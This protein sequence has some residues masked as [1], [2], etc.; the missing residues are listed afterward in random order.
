MLRS[1]EPESTSA[2]VP[3]D[4]V[5]SHLIAQHQHQ[6]YLSSV[7]ARR[8]DHRLSNTVGWLH[9]RYSYPASTARDGSKCK[10]V[11]RGVYKPHFSSFLLL[12]HHRLCFSVIVKSSSR[13]IHPRDHL[14]KG[15]LTQDRYSI[16]SMAPTMQD[17]FC[18]RV[19]SCNQGISAKYTHEP[20]F[21]S[22]DHLPSS[23]TMKVDG[24]W[25]RSE[26]IRS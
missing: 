17:T 16:A 11:K 13:N 19:L 2:L 4:F 14:V 1:P 9:G 24:H 3:A 18:S 15:I 6:S 12:L 5:T 23:S 26:N 7:T 10:H 21:V 22:S 8:W 25:T 20:V